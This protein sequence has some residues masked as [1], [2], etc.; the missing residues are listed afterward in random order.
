MQ[1]LPRSGKRMVSLSSIAPNDAPKPQAPCILMHESAFRAPT[2]T[3]SSP[4]LPSTFDH[5][6]QH[7]FTSYPSSV[8]SIWLLVKQNQTLE[9]LGDNPHCQK[10]KVS[11]RSDHNHLVGAHAYAGIPDQS[12]HFPPH[13]ATLLAKRHVTPVLLYCK[14]NSS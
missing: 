12:T 8:Q 6:R 2:L 9:R 1:C 13:R 5:Q 10:T 14:A 11:R 7:K 3:Q 4:A